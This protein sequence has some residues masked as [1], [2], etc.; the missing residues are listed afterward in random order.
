MNSMKKLFTLIALNVFLL[1]G[2]QAAYIPQ[3]M[4][5][6]AIARD[7]KGE[8]IADKEVYMKITLYTNVWPHKTHYSEMQ[9]VKTNQLGLFSIVIGEGFVETG[10]FD[11]I[12]WSTD[13]IWMDVSMSSKESSDY[14]IISS[15]KLLAVPYAFAAGSVIN[16]ASTPGNSTVSR[17]K[18]TYCPCKDGIQKLQVLYLG[19]N[20]VNINV[21]RNSNLTDLVNTF[22]SV[23][24]GNILTLDATGMNDGK[25]KD[26]TY[27]Q[28][29]GATT[30]LTKINTKCTDYDEDLNSP[31]SGET[32]GSFSILSQTDKSGGYCTA[33]DMKPDWKVGGNALY[34]ACNL[35]GTL[36]NADVVIITNNIE[37]MRILKT[38]NITM[39]NTLS[40][41]NSLNVANNADIS[42]DLTVRNNVNLNTLGGATT[43]YGP[44]TVGNVSPTILTGTLRV[45]Q[46]TDLN[47]GLN[48]NFIKPTVLTG[49]LRVDNAT[50]LFS[51]LTVNNASPTSL[52]GTLEVFLNATMRE[53]LVLNNATHNSTSVS[54][55]AL[56]VAGGVGIG[57]NLNVGG[58]ANF[59]GSTSFAGPVT[60]TD[61][62]PS[63]SC[64]TGAL[65]VAGGAGIS[66][67]LFV[68]DQ[69]KFSSTLDVTGATNLFS[70]LNVSS[71][72][73]L[74]STLSVAGTT[75]LGSTLSVTGITTLNN[76]LNANGQV[77]IQGG[78]SGS[79]L[80]YSNYPLLV[81]GS[82][83]GIAV[84][85]SGPNGA[86]HNYVS[87][88][89]GSTMTGRIEG[90]NLSELHS[91]ANYLLAKRN[92]DWGVVSASL[93][94][95]S[96]TFNAITTGADFIASLSS[97]TACAGLGVC[98][99]APIPSLI[100]KSGV[101]LVLALANEAL[102]IAQI[103]M[104]DQNQT[105]WLA[106]AD[107]SVGV[108]YQSG[109]G[110]Y[111]EYL[112]RS[113]LNEKISS[114]DIVAVSG[115][116]V[117]K[118]T[119]HGD[120]MM[121]VSTKPIVLGNAP[122]PDRENDY[123][124]IA[125][126]GQ[127]P[128]K[129]FGKVNIG[130]Y[131]IPAGGNDGLGIAVSPLE[132]TKDQIKKIVGVAWSASKETY[133]LSRINVAVGLNVND[134]SLLIENLE[135]KVSSQSTEINDLKKQISET[136]KMLAQLVPG[137]TPPATTYVS[138]PSVPVSKSNQEYSLI[139][140]D[141]S[142]VV[143]HQVTR[144]E[145]DKA[146]EVAE[147]LMKEKGVDISNH[148]FWKKMKSDPSYKAEV[149][150]KIE[151]AIVAGIERNKEL[152]AK[153]N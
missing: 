11:A 74:S 76:R 1:I 141:A 79:D 103:I 24:N 25:F 81:Q 67:K 65:I 125:F 6:Q 80:T 30:T 108:T 84:K 63:T 105:D 61:I 94:L 51:S 14:T 19:A 138:S 66:K 41:G 129:V 37:R 23:N 114:G 83:Q 56:V 148:P 46:L 128:V 2:V 48:V 144:I 21:Y 110:D 109:S 123:E 29:V 42:N 26:I 140:P 121:V 143:Y 149:Y 99:T 40:I 34:D 133:G 17:Y 101:N 151:N 68:C 142:N 31:V 70:T 91:D 49:T 127:V 36:S 71:A 130:D 72:S 4:K 132:I 52:S 107:A 28:L 57:K 38:G 153:R 10:L 50:N 87:F 113:D 69:V 20:G 137:F 92:Y 134:N 152:D 89:E 18:I 39:V 120:K 54:N 55:G 131:I 86:V 119:S 96:G 117:T 139:T 118:N 62:T 27:M 60:I 15:T 124:K 45:D 145:L 16:Q 98:V 35:L 93:A 136:N 64:T 150:T 77:T 78:L 122:Q 88:W 12:P 47:N 126:M 13:E 85:V 59:G 8:I 146:V 147:K 44:L 9:K 7:A 32:F 95:A 100:V 75:S 97:S 90:Q 58:A 5:Y 43:N 115:G 111:A 22:T 112:L 104:A 106:N 135:N 102:V 116:K 53:K 33:C 73:V 82:A 3:G